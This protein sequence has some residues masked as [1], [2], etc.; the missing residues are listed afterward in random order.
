MSLIYC[1]VG[2]SG[3]GKTTL[4]NYCSSIGIVEIISSTSRKA[5]NNEVEGKDYYFVDNSDF[6]NSI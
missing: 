2:P 3:S 1:I 6:N 5:R 4:A